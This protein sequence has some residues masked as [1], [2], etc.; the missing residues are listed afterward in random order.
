M[1]RFVYYL[2][3]ITD[4]FNQYCSLTVFLIVLVGMVGLDIGFHNYLFHHYVLFVHE[5]FGIS[6]EASQLVDMG[7]LPEVWLA[8]LALVVG[9]LI[10]VISI[11]AQNVPGIIGLYIR[12]W[13]SLFYL[14][15]IILSSV[16]AIVI[17]FYSE[18]GS[19]RLSSAVLNLHFLLVISSLLALP[20]IFYILQRTRPTNVI[21]IILSKNL[22]LLR[23][24]PSR[25]FHILFQLPTVVEEYQ[26]R[27][28]KSLNQLDDLLEYTDF[29][30]PK[31]E[32]IVSMSQSLQEYIRIKSS[33]SPQFF[34][35]TPTIRSDISF[36]FHAPE[37]FEETEQAGTFYEE[38]FSLILD[39]IY[40]KLLNDKQYQLSSLIY[41]E[42]S[43]VGLAAIHSGDDELVQMIMIQFNTL[44]R[45]TIKQTIA[46]HDVRNLFNAVFGYRRLVEFFS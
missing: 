19:I 36:K 8:L 2:Y 6:L 15:L 1:T 28:C 31:V 38:K 23:F 37:Q 18:A 27:L 26:Y 17:K 13:L 45:F 14:W 9:T 10:I 40:I 20:Y 11:A 42:V 3:R 21:K 35:V 24:L 33:I 12:D 39:G 22:M 32:V 16:H 41:Q 29:K 46:D 34:K 30:E 5:L 44:L 4:F 43:K 7:W 25:P